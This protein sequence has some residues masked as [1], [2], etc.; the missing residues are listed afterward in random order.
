MPA[1]AGPT[2]PGVEVRFRANFAYLDGRHTDG[3]ILKLC[4]LSYAGS[5]RI[6][7]LAGPPR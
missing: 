4:R 7:A 6:D 3:T 5:V 1:A 2:S